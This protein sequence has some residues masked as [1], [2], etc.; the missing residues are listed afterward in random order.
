MEATDPRLP[1]EEQAKTLMWLK[2]GELFEALRRLA[3]LGLNMMDE[4]Y[5]RRHQE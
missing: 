4:E 1:T 2:L 5:H 3:N